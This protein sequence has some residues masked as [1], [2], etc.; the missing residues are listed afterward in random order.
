MTAAHR[1]LPFGTKVR[2][3]NKRNG[4]TVIVT[5]NDRGPFIRGR[6][7]DLSTAAAGVIGMR[8][9]GVAPVLVERIGATKAGASTNSKRRRVPQG[10]RRL[11]ICD[12]D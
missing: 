2:V 3:T 11:F 12:E 10:T 9:S 8:S 5:I 6:I 1:T 7:I 4:K